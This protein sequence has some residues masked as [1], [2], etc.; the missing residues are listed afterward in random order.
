M[1]DPKRNLFRKSS[2]ERLASPEQVDQLMQVIAPKDWLGLT[3]LISLTGCVL[4]WSIFGRIPLTVTGRGVFIYPYRVVELQN[5]S[6]G[7]LQSLSVKAGDVIRK[8]QVLGAIDQSELQEQLRQ[9]QTKLATLQGQ[10][11]QLTTVATQ[12]STADSQA[13][14][15]QRQTLQQQ[16]QTAQSL[17]PAQLNQELQ[18]IAQQ[19]QALRKR[20]QDGTALDVLLKTSL[21]NRQ[22]LRSLGA[23][24]NDSLIAAE[25]AYRENSSRLADLTAQLQELEGKEVALARSRQENLSQ[26]SNLQAQL[27]ELDSKTK[28]LTQQDLEATATRQN[29]VQ[30]TQQKIAQLTLQLKENSQIISQVDGRVLELSAKLGQVLDRGGRLGAIEAESSTKQ[31]VCL[32]YFPIKDGKQIKP[33]MP[34]QITPDSVKREEFGGIVG[35]VQSI[36]PFPVAKQSVA[37]AIGNAEVADSLTFSGGQVEILTTLTADANTTSGYKWSTSQGPALEIS[38]GTTAAVRVTV[39]EQAPI[40]FVFFLLRSSTGL[41]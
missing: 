7:R 11:R 39:G 8:G 6:P 36:A 22:Q 23:I 1:F 4:G 12:R 37:S 16:L 14:A 10:D 17:A 20:V 26:I 21:E 25:Q 3:A 31:L 9:Q 33:E 34:L 28:T 32:T 24:S 13:I 35:R 19:R 18:T 15:Q 2:L 30:E 41:N 27:Q 29:Q 38:P 5:S 40:A